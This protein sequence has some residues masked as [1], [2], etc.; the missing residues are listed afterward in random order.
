MVACMYGSM[1]PKNKKVIFIVI[2]PFPF[3][4]G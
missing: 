4:H 1:V 2:R 3:E